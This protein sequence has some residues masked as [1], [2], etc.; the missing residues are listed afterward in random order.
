MT[1]ACACCGCKKEAGLLIIGLSN[2]GKTTLVHVLAKEPLEHVVPTA[3]FSIETFTAHN[4]KLKTMDMSGAMKYQQ[5]W[6][7]YFDQAQG[8]VFVVDSADIAQ[9]GTARDTLSATLQHAQL[10][11]VP[12]LVL[13][14]K[15]DL[16]GAMRPAEMAQRLGL[17]QFKDR[18]YAIRGC[19]AATNQGVA[20]GF[21]WLLSRTG[22]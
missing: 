6:V 14:N 9:L 4:T 19:S 2:S 22:R 8:I 11:G 7:H 1:A 15:Q 18:E 20:E 13:A 16:A 12:L 3:G 21:D 5:L 17:A 10:Q